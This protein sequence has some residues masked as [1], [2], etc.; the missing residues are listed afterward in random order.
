M[1]IQSATLM[2]L[3][4]SNNSNGYIN[5]RNNSIKRNDI[6]PFGESFH[7]AEDSGGTIV[8]FA[9]LVS[10]IGSLLGGICGCSYVV[11]EK[12]AESEK[13]ENKKLECTYHNTSEEKLMDIFTRADSELG[14]TYSSNELERTKRMLKDKEG[15][16][17]DFPAKSFE[18]GELEGYYNKL[19]D[20]YSKQSSD[21]TSQLTPEKEP[22]ILDLL[23]EKAKLLKK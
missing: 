13:S 12:M 19:L 17:K 5:I 4:Q 8:D 1:R 23:K 22:I 14:C 6:I 20:I 7:E 15:I 11:S 2:P 10:V 16:T 21:S 18:R 9:I 3:C